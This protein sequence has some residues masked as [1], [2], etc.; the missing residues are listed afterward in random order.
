M[1]RAARSAAR[2]MGAVPAATASARLMGCSVTATVTT[3]R[4]C[5]K[6]A[7]SGVT[8]PPKQMVGTP[9]ARAR[10]AT[11]RAVLP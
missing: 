7:P 1:S 5:M 4:S 8:P 11:P 10:S 2:E 9:A 6:A 3:P